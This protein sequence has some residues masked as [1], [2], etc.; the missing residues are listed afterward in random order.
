MITHNDGVSNPLC[1]EQ[2][3]PLSP[4][5]ASPPVDS[6]PANPVNPPPASSDDLIALAIGKITADITASTLDGHI[7][8]LARALVEMG[9]SGIITDS[10][11]ETI[12]RHLKKLNWPRV[13]KKDWAARLREAV[14][15]QAVN[16]PTD[17]EPAANNSTQKYVRPWPTHPLSRRQ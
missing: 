17:T 16:N 5:G 8:D 3:Q 13:T 11:L 10:A 1:S 14:A 12:N 9:A 6:G 15:T 4:W 7:R 2:Q